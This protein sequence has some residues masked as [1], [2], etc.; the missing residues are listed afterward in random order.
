[1][2]PEVAVQVPRCVKLGT[3]RPRW[4]PL[5][6]CPTALQGAV[7]PVDARPSA[8]VVHDRF[9]RVGGALGRILTGSRSDVDRDQVLHT[10]ELWPV[11]SAASSLWALRRRVSHSRSRGI[12]FMDIAPA[13]IGLLLDA[14]AVPLLEDHQG[15]G[16]RSTAHPSRPPLDHRTWRSRGR[17]ANAHAGPR[18][19]AGSP[20]NTRLPARRSYSSQAPATSK[21][22]SG[23]SRSSCGQLSRSLC[24]VERC[25]TTAHVV[26]MRRNYR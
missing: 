5:W 1:V 22:A 4:C 7:T 21:A 14:P 2:A 19:A 6:Q 15:P 18:R 26:S 10:V 11:C 3:S 23:C 17:D 24:T 8:A 16:C 20:C 12:A 13:T 25:G 9:A